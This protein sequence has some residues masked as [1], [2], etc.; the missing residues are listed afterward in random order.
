MGTNSI[1]DNDGTTIDHLLV[2][3]LNSHIILKAHEFAM[4]RQ[5]NTGFCGL[6]WSVLQLS[7]LIFTAPS[8]D[9]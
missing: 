1:T 8:G 6:G 5:N 4:L 9:S 7:S 3:R 2:S